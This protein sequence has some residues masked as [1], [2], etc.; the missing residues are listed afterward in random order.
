LLA[1]DKIGESSIE[2]CYTIQWKIEESSTM[3]I[4]AN[5]M[6]NRRKLN[7]SNRSMLEGEGLI[8][9]IKVT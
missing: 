9:C 1:A 3:Q 5:T 2:E 4:E 6:E 7:N 8:L